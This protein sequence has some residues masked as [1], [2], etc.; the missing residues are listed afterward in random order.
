MN[1]RV[2][3]LTVGLRVWPPREW[4]RLGDSGGYGVSIF[5]LG[6]VLVM[7]SWKG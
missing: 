5:N 6:P 3:E 7:I 1:M 4:F 2:P